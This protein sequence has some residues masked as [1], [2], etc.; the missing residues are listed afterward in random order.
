MRTKTT[1]LA[2][3]LLLFIG[4]GTLSSCSSQQ[5]KEEEAPKDKP[6]ATSDE[7]SDEGWNGHQRLGG[8]VVPK[9]YTLDLTIAPSKETF[10]GRAKIDVTVEEATDRIRMHAERLEFSKV[11]AKRDGEAMGVDANKVKHGGLVLEFE[12]EIAA[13]PLTLTFAYEAPLDEVPEGLYRAKDGGSWY[14]F[15]QFEPLE[16]REAYPCF[17]EPK[18][19]TPFE[20]SLTVPKGKKAFANAPEV[21][22]E[23][24]DDGEMVTH[25]YAET[26]PLPTY[27]VAFAVGNF[28][29]VE[30]EEG[31]I[32]EIPFRI[33]TT[34]GNAD[35]ANYAL[36]KTPAILQFQET[37][38]DRDYPY[39]KLDFVAVPSFAA[40]AMENV[41]LV[42]YRESIL[43]VDPS[44]ASIHDE[45]YVQGIIAHELAHMWFGN[46]V[47]LEWWD[48]LWLNEA[49]A[50][51]MG[52]R[53]VQEVAPELEA[54]LEAVQGAQ[55]VM[56]QD[57][58]KKSRAIRQPIEHGG[59]V[60][61]AFDGITYGKGK[62]VLRM[63]ES[64]LG[65]EDFQKG[66]RAYL[67]SNEHGV[68]TTQKLL[69][70]LDSAS[71]KPVSD[72]IANFLD[73]PGVPL[74]QVSYDKE[75]C[76][77]DE[78][79]TVE[80]EQTRY[81]PKGS[82][83][84]V[85]K[86]WTIPM[87][88][89][90]GTDEGETEKRCLLFEGS[91]ENP[92]RQTVEL[93]TNSCPAW[94][95]PNAD[96][97]GYYHWKLRPTTVQNELFEHRDAL[98]LPEKVA[99]LG[100]FKA[101][102]RAD[103]MAVSEYLKA[104]EKMS[105]E[106]HRLIGGHIIDTIRSYE[107]LVY[108]GT[109]DA[110]FKTFA[111]GI[112]EPYL[113]RVGF[114]ESQGDEA[115]VKMFRPKVVNAAALLAENQE[116]IDK[117]RKK[118]DAFLEDPSSV[119]GPSIKYSLDIAARFGDAELWKRMRKSLDGK[120]SPDL[121]SQVISALG[122]FQQPA[123]AEK[124][125][126][127]FLDGAVRSQNLWRLAGPISD[128]PALRKLAW[129]WLTNNYEAIQ[130]KIGKMRAGSLPWLGSSFCSQEGKER[131]EKFFSQEEHQSVSTP[132][133]LAQALESIEQC[134][135][136]RAL[137]ADDVRTFIGRN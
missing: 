77:K 26:K 6:E 15:T 36:E 76:S 108:E 134:E 16:A 14:A 3:G 67:G 80:L 136:Q 95:H 130:K 30:A 7:T 5:V 124:S 42:T 73:Q 25:A 9:R 53:T 85:G 31:A 79:T 35:L 89:R 116:V 56:S 58:L 18:F 117:A 59:D 81:R 102:V 60:Y 104:L 55:N 100:H 72:V 110:S 127:L 114:E 12:E 10:S 98:T 84:D 101:L 71:G 135:T 24:A 21:G 94:I 8:E 120:L 48:E 122:K 131:V 17:D 111:A 82:D 28:D 128:E 66:V 133:N 126:A 37:Y 46:L 54:S 137:I 78:P 2:V 62:A 97:K 27:L 19:K 63:F 75:G 87:C 129:K 109:P 93:G 115:S 68:G 88:L 34:K 106:K 96:E 64:W 69:D 103:A 20:V 118:T 44:K 39:Q 23:K 13:G 107:D 123:L 29:V 40:G 49:F 70:A 74:V 33:I 121:R 45:Y 125:L 91:D 47:T 92:R 112:I 52:G 1:L 22:K 43:L 65:E 90:L 11:V 61:N 83:A 105:G 99:L 32:G 113:D 86:P 51:W 119:S 50:T 41:G 4:G 132:R 38:F 57:S